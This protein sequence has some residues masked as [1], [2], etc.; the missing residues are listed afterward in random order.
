MVE[1]KINASE[2]KGEGKDLIKNLSDFIKEKTNAE[3]STDAKLLT[4]KGEGEAV[5]KKIHPRLTQKIPPPQR[6]QRHLQS[7]R[8]RTRNP[9]NQ[10]TQTLRSRLNQ[11]ANSFFIASYFYN[12]T[13]ISFLYHFIRNYLLTCIFK[14]IQP[15]SEQTNY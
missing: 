4:V 13:Q 12:F 10:R 9:H 7:H 11:I 14:N 2:L 15:E 8:R 5:S 1:M 6:T 3:V